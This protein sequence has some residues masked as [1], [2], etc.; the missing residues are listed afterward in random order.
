MK[1]IVAVALVLSLSALCG[2]PSQVGARTDEAHALQAGVIADAAGA[3]VASLTAEQRGEAVIDFDDAN[4]MDWHFFPRE[5]RGLTLGSQTDEQRML[6]SDLL[7]EILSDAGWAK[8]HGVFLLEEVIGRDPLNFHATLFGDPAGDKPWGFRLEGHH[9]SINV[10]VRDGSVVTAVPMFFGASPA[11]VRSGVHVGFQLFLPEEQL[12][13]ELVGKIDVRR[14][15]FMPEE[16][17]PEE[18]VLMPGRT[19]NSEQAEGV[20]ARYLDFA[21]RSLLMRLLTAHVNMLHPDLVRASRG[22]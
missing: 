4:R 10:T 5:R 2:E 1:S 7:R 12:A 8:V 17:A 9:V 16:E 18:I 22:R 11:E 6:L 3:W 20:P 21:E 13:R 14:K 19:E 15:E